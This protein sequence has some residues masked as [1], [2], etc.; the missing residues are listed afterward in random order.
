MEWLRGE[1]FMKMDEYQVWTRTTAVYPCEGDLAEHYL[2]S[3]LTGEVGEVA[4]L[5]KRKI[6]DKTPQ[7]VYLADMKKELGDVLWYLARFADE[8]GFSFSEVA[9]ANRDKLVKRLAANTLHGKGDNR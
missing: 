8:L 2:M 6:R 9:E 1:I 5:L 3:A 7:D 4:S